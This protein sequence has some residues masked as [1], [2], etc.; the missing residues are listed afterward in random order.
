M[1]QI[2]I[3]KDYGSFRLPLEIEFWLLREKE[4]YHLFSVKSLD[5]SSFAKSVVLNKI[6]DTEVDFAGKV[7]ERWGYFNWFVVDLHNEC[8]CGLDSRIKIGVERSA[9]LLLEAVKKFK[10]QDLEVV[11]I[12]EELDYRIEQTGDGEKI[13]ERRKRSEETYKVT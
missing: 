9:P 1:K 10:P 6:S 5:S 12:K 4:A 13:I 8:F 11:E 7:S 2:V 3:N